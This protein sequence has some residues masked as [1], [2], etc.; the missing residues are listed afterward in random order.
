MYAI[1]KSYIMTKHLRWYEPFLETTEGFRND[2]DFV[3]TDAF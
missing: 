3:I 2:A 1:T